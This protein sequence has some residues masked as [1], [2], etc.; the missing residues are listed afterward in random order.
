VGRSYP[1]CELGKTAE[2]VEPINTLTRYQVAL[3]VQTALISYNT[4]I[5]Y[6]KHIWDFHPTDLTAFLLVS[7][8]SGF[9]SILAAMWSKT[10][11]A[12][13]VLRISDGWVKRFI[14]VL[15]VSINLVLGFGALS[16]YIQCSPTEK[17][18]RPNMEGECWP[19]E[20]IITYNIFAAGNM[21]N[22]NTP[23][24]QSL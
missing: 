17:L 10:S 23:F 6:G 18:W 11:F 20:T 1:H 21:P 8:T 7:N 16:T 3:V 9:F 24:F 19:K 2:D 13:T 5:G 12:I 15:I 22:R 4:T 14:W